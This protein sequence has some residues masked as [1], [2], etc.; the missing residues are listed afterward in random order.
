MSSFVNNIYTL[1]GL[2]DKGFVLLYIIGITLLLGGVF[3][4]RIILLLMTIWRNHLSDLKNSTL[5]I[6]A[7]ILGLLAIM[8]PLSETVFAVAR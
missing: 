5:R 7:I 6:I 1:F 4:I 8:I 3:N 2:N